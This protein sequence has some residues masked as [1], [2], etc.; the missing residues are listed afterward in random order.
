M[1]RSTARASRPSAK[2]ERAWRWS[3]KLYGDYGEGAPHGT[4]PD[5]GRVQSEGNAYLDQDFPKLDYV[6][7]ATIAE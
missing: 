3:N 4:G 5:Q 1:P 6:K 7:T 2:V